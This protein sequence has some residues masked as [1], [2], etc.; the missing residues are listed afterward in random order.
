GGKDGYLI[1]WNTTDPAAPEQLTPDPGYSGTYPALAFRPDGRFLAAASARGGVQVTPVTEQRFATAGD[2]LSEE[3][4]PTRIDRGQE[5][6]PATGANA[7]WSLFSVAYRPDGNGMAAGRADGGIRLWDAPARSLPDPV[8]PHWGTGRPFSA[9]GALLATSTTQYAEDRSRVWRFPATGRP[10][11]LAELP[12]P[13]FAGCFVPGRNALLSVKNEPETLKLWEIADGTLR[14]GAEFP[15]PFI[16]ASAPGFAM[17]PDGRLLAIQDPTE[18]SVV[19]WDIG[20]LDRPE[21]AGTLPTTFGGQA[22]LSFPVPG[23]LAVLAPEAAHFWD[24]TDPARPR[25]TAQVPEPPRILLSAHGRWLLG[26][27]PAGDQDRRAQQQ[28]LRVWRQQD[29]GT[30]TVLGEITG[31][32]PELTTVRDQVVAVLSARG[33]PVLVD[34][35]TSDE[36]QP[37]PGAVSGLNGLAADPD[38]GTVVGWTRDSGGYLGIWHVPDG[39]GRAALAKTELLVSVTSLHARTGLFDL[40][41]TVRGFTPAGDILLD[42]QAPELEAIGIKTLVI[43]TDLD[44]LRDTLCA[45][46]RL[47]VTAERWQQLLPDVPQRQACG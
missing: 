1:A 22:K 25:A 12:A 11:P 35:G 46:Q 30:G 16:G 21:K 18:G 10:T 6:A 8:C 13:W 14:P 26:T 41:E 45:E 44:R 33:Q 43:P 37:L 24:V 32:E 15:A 31:A 29:D 9:D 42:T 19:L 39:S 5:N 2:L 28:T 4:A 17:S 27:A 7:P 47:T 38:S 3:A 23:V 20:R 36:L 40:R 34:L